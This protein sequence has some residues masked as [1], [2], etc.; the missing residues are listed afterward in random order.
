METPTALA[1]ANDYFLVIDAKG[2]PCASS[3][4]GESGSSI[5]DAQPSITVVFETKEGETVARVVFGEHI[6]AIA[7]RDTR[8]T[9]WTGSREVLNA[10]GAGR[11]WIINDQSGDGSTRGFAVGVGAHPTPASTL[12]RTRLWCTPPDAATVRLETHRPDNRASFVGNGQGLAS[13]RT[14]KSLVGTH[15]GSCYAS[16]H[17]GGPWWTLTSQF[18][19]ASSPAPAPANASAA[20]V[21]LKASSLAPKTHPS[22][23]CSPAATMF[24]LGG[25]RM[26]TIRAPSSSRAATTSVSRTSDYVPIGSLSIEDNGTQWVAR[27][28]SGSV[29]A[30]AA[31]GSPNQRALPGFPTNWQ[32]AYVIISDRDGAV[33]GIGNPRKPNP[34][35]SIPITRI[36]GMAAINA[37]RVVPTPVNSAQ[38]ALSIASVIVGT[39]PEDVLATHNPE[40]YV[41]SAT[42]VGFRQ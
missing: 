5:P 37:I 32:T 13:T 2:L 34:L 27:S 8:Q 40:P 14:E 26:P 42:H 19:P 21:V 39:S 1:N 22:I 25:T 41:D 18:V 6:V 17:A 38:I 35:A 20:L 9:L 36:G 16:A 15:S 10:S 24:D 23:T 30:Q 3:G 33:L 11:I 29:L 4:V 7:S 12:A 31:I 28:A